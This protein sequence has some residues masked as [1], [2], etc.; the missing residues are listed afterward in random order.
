MT[1]V[2]IVRHGRSSANSQGV[3][4]GRLPGVRL[5]DEGRKQAKHAGVRLSATGSQLIVTSPLERT[6]ATAAEIARS[7]ETEA[8]V[9]ADRGFIEC[10]YGDWSGLSIKELSR[11]KLWRE[12]QERPSNVTFPSGESMATMAARA[13]AGV[14][15]WNERAASEG[16]H[17]WVLV[18]HG[19]IIKAIVA[20]ALG[21]HLD[22][23]QRINV[24]PG[25]ISV[26]TYMP[27]GSFVLAV[28]TTDG[29]LRRYATGK[30]LR[31]KPTVGGST[32]K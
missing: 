9:R 16:Q 25:S 32:G 22:N 7:L 6:K 14:R 24:D 13:I 11:R 3:L 15:A 4:A 28:N 5:D 31:R 20:D 1:T 27:S 10:D 18:S 12:I 17:S 29:D 2:F 26:I 23:F 21:M 30:A 8:V 19:D